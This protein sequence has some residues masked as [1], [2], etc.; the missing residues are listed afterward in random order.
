MDYYENRLPEDMLEDIQKQLERMILQ[1]M[2]STLGRL[3]DQILEKNL[4]EDIA[5]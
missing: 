2:L 3:A 1:I 5:F 4:K